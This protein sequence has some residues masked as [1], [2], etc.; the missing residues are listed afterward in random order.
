MFSSGGLQFGIWNLVGA[1][2]T[3][4]A[5]QGYWQGA[6]A[7][8]PRS[9]FRGYILGGLLWIPIPFAFST[10]LGL[11]A[12]AADLPISKDEYGAGLICVAAAQFFM[13]TGPSVLPSLRPSLRAHGRRR[14]PDCGSPCVRACRGRGSHLDGC[15][16]V[17]HVRRIRAVHGHE[18][19]L[20][21][22]RVQGTTRSLRS[23]AVVVV[24][25]VVVVGRGH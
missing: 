11:G 23:T 3:I 8:T 5:D 14:M 12:L 25:V 22:R 17:R 4:F 20:H 7:A 10:A 15:V 21:L 18:L 1:F 16:H 6:I 13:G 24:V 19:A 2:G 9:A